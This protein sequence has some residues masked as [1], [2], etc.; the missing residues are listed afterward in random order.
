MLLVLATWL[1][2][3]SE[4]P[5]TVIPVTPE[6]DASPTSL[7]T[8]TPTV[9]PTPTP[10][11]PLTIDSMRSRAYLGSDITLEQ[12]LT[13]GSN[14]SRYVASYVSD[15]LKIFALLTIPNGT[16]PSTGWPVIIFN[17]G[18]IPPSQYKTTE[19]YVAYVDA[20]ARNGYIVFKSD[21]RGH[22]NS[23]GE[24]LGG[25]GTPD[26]TIDILNALASMKKYRDADPNRIGM[27]GHSMGGQVTLRAMVVSKEIKAGVIW[28][29]VVGSYTD[30]LYHWRSTATPIPSPITGRR[31]RNEFI[32]QYGSPDQNPAFWDSISPNAYL[33][34]ISGPV[35]LHHSTTDA[36]VPYLFSEE[37]DQE[38]V[39]AGKTVEFYGYQ[40]D[41]HNLS[42][43]LVLALQRSVSFF[44]RFVKK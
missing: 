32:D 43:N 11:N 44:D 39:A 29:G 35:Q 6:P 24:A 22:G 17:H 21:Y 27:W 33:M 12:K 19:R 18:Y 16:R 3:C 34:D 31:W 4:I 15:G 36:S 13:A 30:L 38:L 25:Y 20:F 41:D 10:P 26:Y 8:D 14:Y 28:S 40:G 7:P 9:P 2:A 23:E 37:L 1:F 5:P 42:K